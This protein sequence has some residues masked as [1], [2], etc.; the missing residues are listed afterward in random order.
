MGEHRHQIHGTGGI[1]CT[2]GPVRPAPRSPPACCWLSRRRPE[3]HVDGSR[4]QRGRHDGGPGTRPYISAM[5]A[6]VLPC[7]IRRTDRRT[8]ERL[9]E[10]GCSRQ[11]AEDQL[12][13]SASKT[14]DHPAAPPYASPSSGS[15][16]RAN[17][18]VA[19]GGTHL[20]FEL[21]VH[22][23][24]RARTAPPAATPACCASSHPRRRSW[25]PTASGGRPRRSPAGL[26]A[27]ST[28]PASSTWSRRGGGLHVS[29][30]RTAAVAM[31]TMSDSPSSADM[32]PSAV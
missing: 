17:R 21:S 24:G 10:A 23:A 11:D 27:P 30:T 31:S 9:Y 32:W 6:A 28:T 16:V 8:R 15:R 3:L 18:R 2:R 12:D 7:G 22:V 29:S 1:P 5:N 26:L 25:S 13:P 4:P 20:A 19:V 14:L